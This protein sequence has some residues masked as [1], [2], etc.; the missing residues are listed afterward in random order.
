[1]QIGSNERGV[2]NIDAVLNSKDA[3]AQVK[4]LAMKA[5]A[6]EY[7]IPGEYLKS[8]ND[9]DLGALVNIADMS[10]FHEPALFNMVCLSEILASSEGF[11]PMNDEEAR[12]NVGFMVVILTS[13][14]L[15]R[16]GVVI[17]HYDNISFAGTAEQDTIVTLVQ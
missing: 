13:M 7:I 1:M 10:A 12:K 17:V 11:P 4:L 2:L 3:C 15:A 16:K 6:G 5:K 9:L 8:L 14:M